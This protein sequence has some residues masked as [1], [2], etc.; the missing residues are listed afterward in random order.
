VKGISPPAAAGYPLL[1]P[2]IFEISLREISK[3]MGLK[4]YNLAQSAGKW[5]FIS[6]RQGFIDGPGVIF[7]LKA[8]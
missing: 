6:P 2:V 1:M 4:K 8:N 5:L 7:L 3:T